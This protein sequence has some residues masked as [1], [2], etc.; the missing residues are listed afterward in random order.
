MFGFR[1][2]VY[3]TQDFYGGGYV[4]YRTDDRNI[5][6][7]VDALW[8]HFPLP[9]AQV[10]FIAEHSLTGSGDY[11]GDNNRG[12]IYARYVRKYGSSL[13]LP[14]MEYFEAFAGVADHPLPLPDREI[15]GA[16]RFDHQTTSGI[17]Y[18]LDYLTPYWDPEGGFR[19][20]AT[21][22]TGIPIFGEKE[23]FNQVFGQFSF[24]KSLPEIA[25]PEAM[26]PL[27]QWLA[28]T[29]LAFR[30]YGAAGLP[31]KGEYFTLGGGQLFRGYDLKARQGSMVWVG[32]V[33]WRVPIAK[34]LTWD[35]LD[36][37]A[38]VRN[39]YGAAF[40]DAGNAYLRG[41]E[42]GPI[43]H[44]VGAGLRVDVAWFGMIERTT[45]RFDLAKTVND[46]SPLQFWFGIQHPF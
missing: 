8:D 41:H 34:N 37:V 3:R 39:I 25:A 29:R 30:I 13:Y 23:P 12:V 14:P 20:D 32:S 7:G 10:G 36:H 44:A 46:S 38:G 4:A 35:C 42:V 21:Y 24:V 11:G 16:D 18:H 19:L 31:D 26:E 45:M 22:Q 15:P 40:Y 43:A 17:H 27:T 5:V 9:H 2:G 28:Q 6:A 33:E 1:A